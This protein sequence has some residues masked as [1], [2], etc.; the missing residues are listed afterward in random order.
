V[1]RPFR[2]AAA[3][4]GGVHSSLIDTETGEILMKIAFCIAFAGVLAN[5]LQSRAQTRSPLAHLL[6]E[7]LQNNSDLRAA[8]HSWQA[9]TH[10]RAQAAALPDPQF[11]VQEFS[12]GS[13]KPFAGFTTSNFAYIGIGASQELPFPG[14]RALKGK[15]AE[16]A[17]DTRRAQIAV[18]QASI[19]EQLKTAYFRLAYL[20][21]TLALLETSRTTLTQVI[22]SEVARYG[23]GGGSQT[24]VLKAQLERTKLVRE[25]TMHHEE[26]ART[27]AN[28]KQLLHRS[29]DSPDIVAEDLAPTPLRYTAPQLLAF[30]RNQNPEIRMEGNSVAAQN[31]Q[32]KSAGRQGKPDFNIGYMYQRTGLDFPSYY[33]LTFGI[34]LPRRSRV[35][36]E[37]AEA[38]ESVAAGKEHLDAALQQQ[39]AD[40]QKQYVAA[41]SS[42][43]L[44]T[45]YRDGLIPQADAV[46][47]A[48]LAGYKSN[49]E[50]LDSVLASFNEGL[51]L[52]RNYQQTLFDH[53]VAI[54]RLESLTG[55]VLR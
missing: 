40:A 25:I 13:P 32:L 46:F 38:A 29:Q 48:G 34:T 54:A 9:A 21:Q 28:L 39:L 10:V 47:Q 17:A 55:Q 12:V 52:K 15:A 18:L 53:E 33:M 20:Q 50:S 37:V 5:A 16:A 31:A 30:V 45:E 41:T 22:E 14:K 19:A 51:E 24:S 7:A 4:S 8:A 23:A 35:R 6:T 27:E 49:R 42:A 11:T 1:G 44:L 26:M 3:F 36:A 2:A 43:E